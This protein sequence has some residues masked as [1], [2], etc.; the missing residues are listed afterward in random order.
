[1]SNFYALCYKSTGAKG[2]HRTKI[3]L[4]SEFDF[5]NILC[6]AYHRR[7]KIPKMQKKT[8]SLTLFFALMGS[9]HVKAAH[10][11]LVKLTPVV[12]FINIL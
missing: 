7:Q 2:A 6:A 10:K 9:V 4:R 8:D 11:I 3:K 5:T 12:N 1:M